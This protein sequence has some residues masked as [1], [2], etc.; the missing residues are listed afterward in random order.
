MAAPDPDATSVGRSARPTHADVA[1]LANVS[2]ATVS[3]VLNNSAGKRISAR[4][5]EAVYRAAGQLG[6]RPN[7]AARNLARGESGVVLSILPRVAVGDMPIQAGSLMA[8][9]LAQY[10]LLQVQIFETED[11]E[12]IIDAIDNLD[13]I[14][15]VSLFPL[16]SD[17][18][19]KVRAAK[20]PLIE[21][22]LLPALGDPLLTVGAMRVGHLVSRGHRKI[23]FG[24]T[25]IAKWRALG[26]YWLQGIVDAARAHDLPPI[27]VDE[28]T[29]SGAAELV[30]RWV[31]D[32]VT[33]VCAQS[34]EI[35]GLV[36]HGLREAGLRCPHDLAVIG[37][38]ANPM[39]ALC[40]P[41]LTTVE[42]IPAAVADAAIAAVLTELGYPAPP[43]P[44]PTDVARLIVRAST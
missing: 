13:P 4:T 39:G 16:S 20:V 9:A 34:D 10:G 24:R 25:D 26:D 21:I 30:T 28:V 40:D 15:V 27:T 37:I 1:R 35:A 2:T 19:G 38:E 5:R 36:L 6:Y 17:A 44:R 8:A 22:G 14:A 7:V 11:Y 18:R 41:P 12:R 29:A 31:R 3:Y 43:A 23:A 32:G 33:A 42:Y